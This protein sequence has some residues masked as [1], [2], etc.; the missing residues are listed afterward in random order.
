[1][2]DLKICNALRSHYPVKMTVKFAQVFLN[3]EILSCAQLFIYWMLIVF[4][5]VIGD[6]CRSRKFM[7]TI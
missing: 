4:S 6:F 1:V 5:Q 3:H 2:F 7:Q